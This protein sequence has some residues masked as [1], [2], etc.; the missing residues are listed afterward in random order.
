MNAIA[1]VNGPAV[2]DPPRELFT[3]K[4]ALFGVGFAVID[5]V[6]GRDHFSLLLPGSPSRGRDASP[7][8]LAASVSTQAVV[9]LEDGR[10]GRLGIRP[11]CQQLLEPFQFLFQSLNPLRLLMQ[12]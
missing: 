1:D 5:V 3:T 6:L 9:F 4:D 8:P 11:P 2:D 12:L 7:L 10:L